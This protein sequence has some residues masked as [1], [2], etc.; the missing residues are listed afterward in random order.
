[1][2]RNGQWKLCDVNGNVAF[3]APVGA[4]GFQVTKAGV[5]LNLT[6][7]QSIFGLGETTGT[8]NKRGLIRELWNIDVLGHAKAIYTSLRSLYVSIPFVVSLQNGIAAGLFWDNPARQLW[9]IGQT[10]QDKW[11]MTAASG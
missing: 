6:D 5:T 8:Y 2:L 4:T 10:Y 1:N 7:N 9:D 11:Q 3:E